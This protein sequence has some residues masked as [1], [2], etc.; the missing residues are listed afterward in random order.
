MWWRVL[1][2]TIFALPLCINLLGLTGFDSRLECHS[3]RVEGC[4]ETS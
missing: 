3:K 4:K 2:V 1:W